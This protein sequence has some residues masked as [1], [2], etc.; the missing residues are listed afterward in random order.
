[1]D[2]SAR[3]LSVHSSGAGGSQYKVTA[4]VQTST[5]EYYVTFALEPGT[6]GLQITDHYAIKVR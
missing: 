6:G 1:M 4:D 3:V 2:S 5:G